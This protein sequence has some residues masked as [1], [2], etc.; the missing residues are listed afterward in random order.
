MR[1]I[2]NLCFIFLVCFNISVFSQF[3]ENKGQVLDWDENFHPEVQYLYAS[4][5]NS[6]FFESNRVVCTFASL[7]EFDFSRYER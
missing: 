1:K 3:I 5:N 7:D 4:N 6:M 2:T